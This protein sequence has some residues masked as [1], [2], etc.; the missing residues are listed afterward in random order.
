MTQ[1][2]L[3]GDQLCI[4]IE[5][6]R[7]HGMTQMMAGCAESSLFGIILHSSLN[8]SDGQRLATTGTFVIQEDFLGSGWWPHLEIVTQRPEGIVTEVDDSALSPFGIVDDEPS[9]L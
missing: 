9:S 3:Y 4:C 6:L 2:I 1:E 5:H 8:A 7:G